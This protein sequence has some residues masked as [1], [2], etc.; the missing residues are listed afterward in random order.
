[1]CRGKQKGQK[2]TMREDGHSLELP[3]AQINFPLSRCTQRA[4]C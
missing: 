2:E 4:V 1:M 3:Q